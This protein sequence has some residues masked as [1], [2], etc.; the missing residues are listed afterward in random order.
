MSGFKSPMGTLFKLALV[1]IMI[2]VLL[3]AYEHRPPKLIPA[4]NLL[5]GEAIA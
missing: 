3:A 2:D 1:A 5:G 4:F